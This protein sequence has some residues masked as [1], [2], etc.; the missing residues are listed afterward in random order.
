MVGVKLKYVYNYIAIE[1]ARLST[2][3]EPEVF[4]TCTNDNIYRWFSM[5][6]PNKVL[7]RVLRQ[8]R[9]GQC[10]WSLEVPLC[11]E[12]NRTCQRTTFGHK[13]S[14][15]IPEFAL[16]YNVNNHHHKNFMLLM[17]K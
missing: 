16:Q 15:R 17:C 8:E 3:Q 7:T 6:I 12:T 4:L 2:S 14:F 5:T 9:Y 11:D 1:M 13:N 10:F